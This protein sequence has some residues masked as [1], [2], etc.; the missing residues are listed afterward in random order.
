MDL[1]EVLG[2]NILGYYDYYVDSTESRLYL[3]ETR[4]P[5]FY[6]DRL[7]SGQVFTNQ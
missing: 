6:D 7:K 5:Y 4:T 1:A 3:K 2:L